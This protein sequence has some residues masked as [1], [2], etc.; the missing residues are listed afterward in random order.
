L[1]ELARK[2]CGRKA[3]WRVSFPVLQRKC[4]SASTPRE[5]RRLVA[6]IA[7][8]DEAHSHIPDYGIRIEE[9]HVVFLN[10]EAEAMIEPQALTQ[11]PQVHLKPDTYEAAR[12]AAPGW[13]IYQLELE[14][15][16]WMSDGGL[17]A[18]K[19]ADRAFLGFCRKWFEKRGTA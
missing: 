9:A 4:G 5:F 14:W 17:D 7:R 18:P 6:N 1:Y 19:D 3:E 12:S 15:R 8:Q 16:S 2:H 10:R 11:L 13:D